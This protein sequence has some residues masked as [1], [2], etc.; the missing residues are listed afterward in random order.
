M[1]TEAGDT[2]QQRA[3]IN[4]WTRHQASLL[5][6]TYEEPIDAIDRHGEY[7]T[8][9]DLYMDPPS[10]EMDLK[11]QLQKIEVFKENIR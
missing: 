7:D 3:R 9:E 5:S 1:D 8:A 4:L 10:K 11:E 2:P 6:G